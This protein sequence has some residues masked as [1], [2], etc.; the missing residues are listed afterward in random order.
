VE[1][2]AMSDNLLKF[3]NFNFKLA[4]IGELMYVQE[5]LPKYDV[6]EAL[7]DDYVEENRYDEIPEARKF[8]E[9]LEIDKK[10]ADLVEEITED[11]D[12]YHN[13][14]PEWGG[15]DLYH[16]EEIS[17]E[18][19]KQFKNLKCF[20]CNLCDFRDSEEMQALMEKYGIEWEN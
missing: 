13:L 6:Y 11:Y 7:G 4:I 16:M 2:S 8:F 9:E 19:L 10:Y 18:E 14:F 20:E 15:D 12:V 17:E 1:V 5:V 3:D